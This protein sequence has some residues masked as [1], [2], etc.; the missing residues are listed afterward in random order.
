[1]HSSLADTRLGRRRQSIHEAAAFRSIQENPRVPQETP[2][3]RADG[4]IPE[5]GEYTHYLVVV[6]GGQSLLQAH[7]T[8]GAEERH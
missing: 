3:V 2:G 1:M 4:G 6:R 5:D 7:G 8:P